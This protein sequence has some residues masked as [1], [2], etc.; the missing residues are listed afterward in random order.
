MITRV[1]VDMDGVMTKFSSYAFQ[2][3]GV[4]D[5]MLAY[6]MYPPECQTWDIVRSANHL[7]HP[8]SPLFTSSRFWDSLDREFWDT[9]PPEHY[10]TQLITFLVDQV[11]TQNV[12]IAS[13]PTLCPESLAG[14]LTWIK[15]HLPSYMHRQYMLGQDKSL[16][17]RPDT[18]LIDD[19]QDNCVK[20]EISGGRS[21]LV[22]RPWNNLFTVLSSRDPQGWQYVQ[23]RLN[24]YF[25]GNHEYQP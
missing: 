8:D 10:L 6:D 12:C 16:L 21:I 25:G 22:P 2:Y 18:L 20:F 4:T 5:Y 3:I 9:I 24:F 11:G 23:H 19:N 15:K 17:A 1:F 13:T 14:K 7:R